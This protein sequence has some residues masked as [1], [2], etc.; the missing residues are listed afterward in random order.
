M[1]TVLKAPWSRITALFA[2]WEVELTE[3]R[4]ILERRIWLNR[5][6]PHVPLGL[7]I[8]T[9]GMVLVLRAA[10]AVFGSSLFAIRFAQLERHVAGADLGGLPDFVIGG[11][12]L[13]VAVGLS[14]RSWFAW[15][16][17]VLGLGISLV[18]RISPLFEGASGH[19][20]FLVAPRIALLVALVATRRV[21]RARSASTQYAFGLYILLAFLVCSTVLTLQNGTHFDPEI[22]DPVTALYFVVVTI[23]SVGFGD[24]TPR[25]PTARGFVMI[26]I[27]LG[28]LV[29]GT[30]FSTFLLPLVSSRLR[31]L[32]GHKEFIVNRTKHYVVIGNS[33]LARNAAS[34]LE[35]RDQAVTIILSKSDEGSFYESRDVV[36][37]DPTDLDVLRSAGVMKAR[38]VLSLSTD[39]ATNGFVVLGVNELN[40]TVQT[41]AALNDPANKSRLDRTQ[42]SLLLSLH[43]LG[44]QLLAMA[45]TGEHVD[46]SML[47][48]A[49][50]VHTSNPASTGEH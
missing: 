13:V 42:P 39:D 23:S 33:A 45:L 10:R 29:V 2:H 6:F 26:V 35:K 9:L 18:L 41:V 46:E 17:T 19:D 44:G 27:I 30:A 28:L 25:D 24:F 31:R 8:A 7:A 4:R 1:I 34:E 40:P 20:G 32:L 16:L 22:Q 5:W 3:L 12:L 37:G 11:L 47:D 48:E 49:L 15:W 36:I 50:K 21:F 38:G 43:V 14:R